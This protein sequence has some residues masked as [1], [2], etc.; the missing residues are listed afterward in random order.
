MKPTDAAMQR[1]RQTFLDRMMLQSSTIHPSAWS[2]LGCATTEVLDWEERAE[3]FTFEGVPAV[4]ISCPQVLWPMHI[5]SL[6][7]FCEAHPILAANI[8]GPSFLDR[9]RMTLSVWRS[10]VL[11]R[12]QE[13][14]RELARQRDMVPPKRASLL[15]LQ[16]WSFFQP[17]LQKP[18]I[19]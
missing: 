15:A 7:K 19:N 14:A 5:R 13:K 9:D 11:T 3:L 1:L 2:L 10:D 4:V 16:P 17:E 12:M 6:Q 8:A 18:G